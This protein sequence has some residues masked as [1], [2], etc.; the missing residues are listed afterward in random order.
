MNLF[1]TTARVVQSRTKLVSIACNGPKDTA[2]VSLTLVRCSP[3][4]CSLPLVND[5]AISNWPQ[6]TEEHHFRKP[7]PDE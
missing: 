5:G 6:D 3:E 1:T 7:I 2:V 4:Q